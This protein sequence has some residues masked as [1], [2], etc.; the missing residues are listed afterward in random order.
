M[1]R[2]VVSLV[3]AS[4]LGFQMQA[5]AM[6][7]DGEEEARSPVYKPTRSAVKKAMKK[8]GIEFTVD[9]DGDI[10]YKTDDKGWAIYVLFDE[11]SGRLWNVQ[12]VA[13]FATKK[14]RYDELIEY[15]NSWNANKKYPKVSMVDRDSLMV[16]FFYPLQY[17][18][19]PDE[20]EDNVIGAFERALRIIGDETYEMRR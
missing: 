9:D 16:E 1:K 19:N 3:L 6:K 14:S 13:Q 4:L 18:F 11:V 17:G 15:A 20:F 5:N 10:K 12:V 8:M 2:I 7:L